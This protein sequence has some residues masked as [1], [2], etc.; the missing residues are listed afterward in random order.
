MSSFLVHGFLPDEIMAVALVPIIKSKSGRIALASIVSKVLEKILLNRLYIFLDTCSHQF[1]FKNK[2]STDQCVFVLKEL[3]DSFRML[4]GSIFTCFLDASKAFDRVNH[5]LLFDKLCAR[6]V[7]FYLIRLLVY[8]YEHQL[9]CV[10]WGGVYSSSSTVTNGVRQGGIL[11]PYLFNVYVDDLSVK[12][13]SCHV[14]CYYSGG[15]INHL[16][17]ADDLVIMSPSVAGL[18]KLANPSACHMMFCLTT[19]RVQSCRS[20]LGISKMPN[21]LCIP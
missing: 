9:M 4:N 1:G 20:E 17:Y 2:H 14:G 6:G 8:W 11:S 5:S 13:N 15:C 18:Y 10:R 7:P 16:M 21:C 19:K 3:I 12:L